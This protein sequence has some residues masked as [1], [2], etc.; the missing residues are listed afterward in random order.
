M[1]DGKKW[2]KDKELFKI[3][4][5]DSKE[6]LKVTYTIDTKTIIRIK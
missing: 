6:N 2:S 3:L 4:D 5:K 1:V